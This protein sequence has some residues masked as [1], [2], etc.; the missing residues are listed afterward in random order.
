V[1]NAEAQ[2]KKNNKIGEMKMTSKF[3]TALSASRFI[4][5][6]SLKNYHFKDDGYTQNVFGHKMCA[7]HV[8]MFDNGSGKELKT[9]AKAVYSSSMLAYNFFHWISNGNPFRYEDIVYNDVFFEVK[10]PTISKSPASANIDVVLV[11]ADKS[12]WLMFESKF[13]EH[14]HPSSQQMINLSHG[15]FDSGR[16]LFEHQVDADKIIQLIN[17]WYEK[18]E[19]DSTQYYDGIKQLICHL[20]AI[21]NLQNS[22]DTSLIRQKVRKM[23]PGLEELPQTVLFRTI[24]FNP[25]PEYK[26]HY[27]SEA[28]KKLCEQ[29]YASTRKIYPI[30][31]ADVITY[32]EIWDAMSSQ[33]Q[34]QRLADFLIDRYLR[35]ADINTTS[36]E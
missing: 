23:N 26:E 19:R 31:N 36:R 16:Y 2:R 32:S 28:Y 15:Y 17:E 29:F 35:C 25:K 22:L 8:A 21:M 9:K 3:L 1:S 11:S 34:D 12:T 27:A 33:L 4:N 18:A 13:T 5:K 30:L 7:K 20:V 10:I 6:T 24:L 14:F